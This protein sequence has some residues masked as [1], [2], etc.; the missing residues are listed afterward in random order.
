[1]VWYAFTVAIIPSNGGRTLGV[2]IGAVTIYYL[3]RP[4]VKAYVGKGVR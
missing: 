3:Y 4:H 1:M 2:I